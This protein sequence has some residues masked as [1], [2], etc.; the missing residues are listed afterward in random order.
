MFSILRL[1]AGIITKLMSDN[2]T[3]NG[4]SGEF[5]CPPKHQDLAKTLME[6]SG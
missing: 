5:T 4:I 1:F 2:V 3:N 6:T